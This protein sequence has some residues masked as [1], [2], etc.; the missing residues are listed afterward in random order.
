MRG[1]VVMQKYISILLLTISIAAT[2]SAWDAD[3]FQARF[4]QQ[5]SGP[6]LS[7]VNADALCQDE[8]ILTFDTACFESSIVKIIKKGD[9]LICA[10]INGLCI[11]D[12]DLQ[13]ISKVYL[14]D[15]PANDID[16]EGEYAYLTFNDSAF[17]IVDIGNVYHPVTVGSYTPPNE[18]RGVNVVDTIAYVGFSN[19]LVSLNVADPEDIRMIDSISLDFIL[20][21]R[22]EIQDSTAYV[23]AGT[24]Y[25]VD[26]TD[27]AELRIIDSLPEFEE[28]MFFDLSIQDT[29][30]YAAEASLTWPAYEA[31]FSILDLGLNRISSHLFIRENVLGVAVRDTLAFV[32]N[33]TNGLHIFNVADPTNPDIISTWPGAG[34]VGYAYVEGDT[35]YV[36]DFSL[37]NAWELPP[38]VPA[39]TSLRPGDLQ[40]LDVSDPMNPVRVDYLPLRQSID[41]VT[42]S[43][44]VVYAANNTYFASSIDVVNGLSVETTAEINSLVAYG[45]LLLA[46]TNYGLEIFDITIRSMPESL[47]SLQ[48]PALDVFIYKDT[49]ALIA[50]GYSGVQF[51]NI[52]DPTGPLWIGGFNTPDRAQEIGVVGNICYVADRYAI[53]RNG[54]GLRVYDISDL[55]GTDITPNEIEIDLC[56]GLDIWADRLYVKNMLGFTVFDIANPR[57]PEEI[58]GI[59]TGASYDLDVYKNHVVVCLGWWGASIYSVDSSGIFLVE[60]ISTPGVCLGVWIETDHRS[61]QLADKWS[62]ISYQSRFPGDP[63]PTRPDDYVLHQNYPNPFNSG[64]SIEFELPASGYVDLRVYNILGQRVHNLFSGYKPLG[65]HRVEWDGTTSTGNNA[66]TGIYF[67][68]LT[69]DGSSIA[70]KM[71]LL[72]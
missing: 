39:D 28:F 2:V 68:R 37:Y 21:F 31:R 24:L 58:A 54:S 27:P 42:E 23:A 25:S 43:N 52:A 51:V 35:V 64:T 60:T 8:C 45:N 19:S 15:G 65:L 56:I 32:A 44:G 14:E 41:H 36:A 7:K 18:V 30:I 9:Y 72:K 13:I 3:R 1:I 40:K 49:I 26:I 17:H 6:I 20:P 69:S 70:R 12:A 5:N 16:V 34:D 50:T 61:V 10:W 48:Y 53:P 47:S 33:R 22:I 62:L 46:A 66:A 59:Y 67:Y 57:I 55:Q 4:P 71:L 29:L 11:I 63:D 38:P